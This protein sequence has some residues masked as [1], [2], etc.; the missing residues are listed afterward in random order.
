MKTVRN[1][2]IIVDTNE[3]QRRKIKRSVEAAFRQLHRLEIDILREDSAA[4]AQAI[5]EQTHQKILVVIAQNTMEEENAGLEVVT[6]A[7]ELKIPHIALHTQGKTLPPDTDLS[8]I[9]IIE[10][11]EEPN[12]SDIFKAMVDEWDKSTDKN[13]FDDHGASFAALKQKL[14]WRNIKMEKA[15]IVGFLNNVVEREKPPRD[16]GI[17][18]FPGWQGW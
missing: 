9:H 13:H 14:E 11:L 4:K 18:F 7:R 17:H 10:Q 3:S 5:I 2:V 6:L 1:Q 8:G 12:K 16:S 15:G